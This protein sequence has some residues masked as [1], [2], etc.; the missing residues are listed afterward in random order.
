MKRKKKERKQKKEYILQF[1]IL[2]S[3]INGIS[4]FAF[5]GKLLWIDKIFSRTD[6]T[7]THFFFCLN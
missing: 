7:C 5:L 1:T 4:C 3:L 2:I 6:A